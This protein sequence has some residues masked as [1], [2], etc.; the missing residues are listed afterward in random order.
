MDKILSLTFNIKKKVQKRELSNVYAVR[1]KKAQVA[2]AMMILTFLVIAFVIALP[3]YYVTSSFFSK[4]YDF[5][6]TDANILNARLLSCLEKEDFN[7]NNP[8]EFSSQLLHKCKINER[9]VSNSM[10][11]VI[12]KDENLFFKIGSGDVTSCN[13]ASKNENFPKCANSTLVKDFEGKQSTLY[14]TTGSNQQSKEELAASS[15][16][17]Y[18]KGGEYGGA[19]AGGSF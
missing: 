4:S 16:S 7:L 2:S 18:G 17:S 19:G 5:R 12:Y 10:L 11:I 3:V 8:Q 13:L 14:L 6:E 1:S 9:V 15:D